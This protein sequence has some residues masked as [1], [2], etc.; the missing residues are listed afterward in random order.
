MSRPRLVEL[1]ELVSKHQVGALVATAIDFVV[2]VG[3]VEVLHRS[4][5]T[6]TA[7]GAATGAVANFTLGRNWIFHAREGR[8]PSQALRY[9]MVSAAS[10]LLNAA[11]VFGLATL[12]PVHYFAARV[13][14]AFA[15]SLL[16]NFPMHRHFVFR[17]ASR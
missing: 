4:A 15:V 14:T 7:I 5:V 8:A 11:G 1:F 6:G 12:L 2:M 13:C 10:L 16:W 3:V 17:T 9:A